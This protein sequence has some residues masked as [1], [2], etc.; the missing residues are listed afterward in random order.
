M[1]SLDAY[2]SENVSVLGTQP[3]AKGHAGL[4][5]FGFQ[6]KTE[7][8][9]FFWFGVFDFFFLYVAVAFEDFIFLN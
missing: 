5:K 1:F 8:E 6:M 4:S 9:G 2:L 7:S 3:K